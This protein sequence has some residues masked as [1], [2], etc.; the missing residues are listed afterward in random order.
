MSMNLQVSGERTV[1]VNK[2]G[3]KSK[4]TTHFS[5]WQ[6]PTEVT[7]AA[8]KGNPKQFYIDWV[9]ERSE[10]E[11]EEVFAEDDIWCEREPIGTRTSNP[12]LEHIAELE[13]W[14]KECEDEG[15]ELEWYEI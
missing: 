15:Y 10:D 3:K 13:Q 12:G 6:T 14:L 1:T 7:R 4:Q 9:K 8:L 5:L 2:T 11:T